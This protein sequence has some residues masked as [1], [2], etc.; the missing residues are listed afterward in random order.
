MNETDHS[1]T[2]ELGVIS[3]TDLAEFWLNGH[4]G[5]TIQVT[6][7]GDGRVVPLTLVEKVREKYGRVFFVDEYKDTTFV[8]FVLSCDG[9]LF[10]AG[11][12][13]CSGYDETVDFPF[14]IFP[15]KNY[16]VNPATGEFLCEK[17]ES[18]TDQE[19]EPAESFAPVSRFGGFPVDSSGKQLET[20]PHFESHPLV[21]QAQ[22]KLPDGRMVWV[23][24][25]GVESL[26]TVLPMPY[27]PLWSS[28]PDKDDELSIG[29]NLNNR[30]RLYGRDQ[31]HYRNREFVGQVRPVRISFETWKWENNGIAV[32]VEGGS[33]PEWIEMKKPLA[34]ML[35][36]LTVSERAASFPDGMRH[37]PSWIQG[38]DCVDYN[39]PNFLFQIDEGVA[40]FSSFRGDLSSVYVFWDGKD[41]ARGILQ[42]Y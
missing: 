37:V 38:D 22:Y 30:E 4:E 19:C 40:G 32:I 1:L 12:D 39:F 14:E 18:L 10:L 36:L 20:W 6:V 35:P 24:V 9:L 15:I 3:S 26:Q 8:L 7:D 28:F 25:D 13:G 2:Q 29:E 23:F 17:V 21:F 42:C 27:N 16:T 34:S 33:V 11:Y 5:D 41:S 31:W